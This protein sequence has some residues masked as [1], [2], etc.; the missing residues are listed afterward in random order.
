MMREI[1][2]FKLEYHSWIPCNTLLL[3]NICRWLV[4]EEDVEA[5]GRA[6]THD[7]RPLTNKLSY[8]LLVS[9]LPPLHRLVQLE[10]GEGQVTSRGSRHIILQ[11]LREEGTRWYLI[12]GSDKS[13]RS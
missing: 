9:W 1:S 4:E 11:S 2:K 6:T 12:I 3:S 7:H 13:I 5:M 8:K 10:A